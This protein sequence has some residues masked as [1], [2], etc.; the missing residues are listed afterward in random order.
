MR[1]Y[2]YLIIG[3][4][5]AADAAVKG[6]RGIDEDWEICVIGS[7]SV[8]PYKRPPLTKQ[9]WKGKPLESIWLDTTEFAITL[10][11]SRTATGID[12]A[13]NRVTDDEG[14]E[15]GFD[16]LLIATGGTPRRLPFGAEGI[17]YYRTFDDYNALRRLCDGGEHF[18]VIGGGFI[19]SEIAAALA[20]NDKRA[21]MIFLGDAIGSHIYPPDLARFVTDYYTERG[22]SVRAGETVTDIQGAP[23]AYK[24]KTSSGAEIEVDGVIAGIGITP[25]TQLA[26][27]AGLTVDNGIVVDTHL[28]AGLD[29]V[30]AAGDVANFHDHA[31]NRRMRV[32][33]EDNAVT[34]GKHAGQAMAG[35][36]KPYTHQ[37]YFYSDMFDLGYEAVGELDP[38]H[39]MFSDWQDPFNKGV[40]YYL[41]NGRVRGV[42]L[43][44]VWDR[45]PAARE[46]IAEPGPF[47]PE[48]LKGRI[49]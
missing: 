12:L 28:R 42:L 14:N 6:I 34:M 36:M 44:N 30:F 43:W 17:I 20:M 45:V 21:T 23:G 16:K 1:H 25:N 48:D 4:G 5:M 10:E 27:A 29:H 24:I 35:H 47:S 37:P 13:D 46:L 38:G 2:A 31:L 7:E 33:H 26:E 19:G 39:E 18:A 8:P 49:A 32:E 22:V 40:V 3:G 9:L 15:Y 41:S 11:L